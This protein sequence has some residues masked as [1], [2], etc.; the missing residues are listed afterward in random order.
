MNATQR[1]VLAADP[2]PEYYGVEPAKDRDYGMTTLRLTCRPDELDYR[3][4]CPGCGAKADYVH[5][6][7]YIV[8]SPGDPAPEIVFACPAHDPGGYGMPLKRL[9]ALEGRGWLNTNCD[10]LLGLMGP[11]VQELRKVSA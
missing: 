1:R 6:V 4:D 3:C 11:R 2:N 8:V 7:P 5:A 9:F 10:R